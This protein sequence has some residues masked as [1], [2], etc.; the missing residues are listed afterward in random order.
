MAAG[1]ITLYQAFL[2][3]LGGKLH[4][5]DAD[6]I[7]I[8]LV[9]TSYTPATGDAVP[10]WGAGGTTNTSTNQVTPGGNYATGGPD[11]SATWSQ[12]SGLG[13]FDATDVSI[14]QNASN[15]TN[16][17]WGIIYN[18]TATNKNCI[19]FVD[20]GS[21]VDLSAGAFSIV[22]NA[23]GINTIGTIS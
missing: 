6:V 23:S 16:A 19:G 10:C 2:D 12:T 14:A 4:D 11:I 13:T 20:L 8:G 15:P 18:D 3:D 1:D 21:A 9:T 17:R 5:L 22:W 7:K